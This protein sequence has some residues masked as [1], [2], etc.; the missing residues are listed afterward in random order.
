VN[1]IKYQY[2]NRNQ[3][4]LGSKVQDITGVRHEVSEGVAKVAADK[5]W[6]IHFSKA[7]AGLKPIWKRKRYRKRLISAGSA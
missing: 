6:N 4:G 3:M 5:N 2:K 7:K 1:K